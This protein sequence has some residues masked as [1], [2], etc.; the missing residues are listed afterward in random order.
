MAFRR[1]GGF[2]KK[3]YGGGGFGG[4]YKKKFGGGGFRGGGYKKR[5]FGGGFGGG[6]KKKFGGGGGSSRY[7]KGPYGMKRKFQPVPPAI[8]GLRR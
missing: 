7:S 5:S 8:A 6:Y 1:Q 3:S 2:F 4:G